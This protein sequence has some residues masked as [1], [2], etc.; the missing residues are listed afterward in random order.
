MSLMMFDG[1][2]VCAAP[3]PVPDDDPGDV[4]DVF[5]FLGVLAGV[6]IYIICIYF[7]A[8]ASKISE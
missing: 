4:T 7:S 2:F 1:V 8:G 3:V 5:V 6:A